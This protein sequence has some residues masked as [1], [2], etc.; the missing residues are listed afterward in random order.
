MIPFTPFAHIK[1]C[2]MGR[3]ADFLAAQGFSLQQLVT[4]KQ[5]HGDKIL[6][7]NGKEDI[8]RVD[9]V[10]GDAVISG[11][12]GVPIAVK[13][14]DCV[15]ILMAHPKGVVAAVHAGW[16]GTAEGI[17]SKTLKKLQGDYG[18]D[19]GQLKLAIGP[20]I[21]GRCYEVEAE[22]VKKFPAI[23]DEAVLNKISEKKYLLDLKE[24]NRREALRAGLSPSQ[25]QLHGDCTRCR[26]AD[27]FS[28]REA[29]ARGEKNIGR[30]Y[31]WIC[32]SH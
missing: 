24:Y 16:R 13:S 5:V 14:A 23:T 21:C 18:L 19:L 25:V 2:F 1:G 20:A 10:Q 32:L 9:G 8:P 27:Y 6:Q 7:I 30:N 12:R 28:Y 15:P 29:V 4:L 17:L 3:N 26:Y 31:S 22:V 11:A